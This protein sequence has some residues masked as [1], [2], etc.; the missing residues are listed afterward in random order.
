ML[1]PQDCIT[2]MRL[3]IFPVE[4]LYQCRV[5]S[6]KEPFFFNAF[7]LEDENFIVDDMNRAK[8]VLTESL[9]MAQEK[10]WKILYPNG[11]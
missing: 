5:K 8:I 2:L 3:S 7:L 10:V 1:S 11:K 6:P 9:R 4:K